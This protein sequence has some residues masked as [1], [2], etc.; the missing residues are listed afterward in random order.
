MNIGQSIETH[1][2]HGNFTVYR[3]HRESGVSYNGLRNIIENKGSVSLVTLEKLANTL[4][5]DLW[6]IVKD[7][8]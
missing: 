7:A 6:R 1:M 3:L 5:I 2:K 4:G 8:Q